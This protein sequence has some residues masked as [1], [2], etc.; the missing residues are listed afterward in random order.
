[1]FVDDR[2]CLRYNAFI[3]LEYILNNIER[4]GL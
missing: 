3:V 4:V 1:M 2:F